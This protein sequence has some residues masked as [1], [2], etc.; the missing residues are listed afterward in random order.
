MPNYS[1]RFHAFC[2][3]P[4]FS[5]SF[6][7]HSSLFPFRWR[8]FLL[9][10]TMVNSSM[11]INSPT[12]CI[13]AQTSG[14][15]STFSV[16]YFNF[17]SRSFDRRFFGFSLRLDIGNLRYITPFEMSAGYRALLSV[18]RYLPFLL[19]SARLEPQRCRRRFAACI[20]RGIGISYITHRSFPVSAAA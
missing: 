18:A 13:V 15:I 6:S 10:T 4:V 14:G 11:G 20:V 1:G 16:E 17:T 2:K 9:G 5:F 3:K 8:A 7:C 12:P 19:Q